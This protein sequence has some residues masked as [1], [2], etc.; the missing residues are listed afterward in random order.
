MLSSNPLVSFFASKHSE[1]LGRKVT[2]IDRDTVKLFQH[3]H[4][5][6]NVRELENVVQRSVIAARSG[7]LRVDPA[8]LTNDDPPQKL[9]KQLGAHELGAIETAL[10]AARGR[11]SG[12]AGAAKWL[13]LP[14]ST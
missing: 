6:G 12:S 10:R 8:L 11:V 1:R 3:Y 5:P 9:G 14:P 4:W 7:R 13:G 2:H